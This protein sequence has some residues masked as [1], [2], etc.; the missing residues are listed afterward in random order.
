[1]LSESL[2]HTRKKKRFHASDQRSLACDLDGGA[3]SASV[4]PTP[5]D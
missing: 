1:M 5:A 3:P 2:T 4:A